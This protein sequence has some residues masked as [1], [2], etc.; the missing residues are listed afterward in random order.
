MTFG[1]LKARAGQ[2]ALNNFLADKSYV[3]GWTP[4]QADNVIFEAL[5]TA[6][7]GDLFNALRWFNHINSWSEAERKAFTGTRKPVESY[8]A[9]APAAAGKK[10]DDDVDLFGSDDEDDEEK[11]RIRQERMK[12][13]AAKKSTKPVLVAKSMVKMD[14]KP[15]DD[16]TDMAEM[17]RQV[18]SIQMDGLV[19]G[20]F[21]LAPVAYGLK[22]LVISCVIEDD[23][24]STTDLEEKICAFE[25]LVQS[26]DVVVFNK[27]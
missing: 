5:G 6:P 27:L 3:E 18:K 13:Y 14:V 26:V 4:S 17:E 1:D 22:K 8:G 10:D 24:V 9:A 25:D 16:E 12:A 19:W 2:Q 15:W 23:K 11:E 20:Q 7:P 21:Q